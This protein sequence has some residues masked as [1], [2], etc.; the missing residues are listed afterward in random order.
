MRCHTVRLKCPPQWGMTA[1]PGRHKMEI[2]AASLR[3]VAGR[4]ARSWTAPEVRGCPKHLYQALALKADPR[5]HDY[6]LV[7]AKARGLVKAELMLKQLAAETVARAHLLHHLE[8]HCAVHSCDHSMLLQLLAPA[9]AH[10]CWGCTCHCA[11]PAAVN[12]SPQQD[13]H[14]EEESLM[15]V[16]GVSVLH[17]IPLTNSLGHPPL[18]SA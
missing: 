15:M 16:R 5:F 3:R 13:E 12:L 7:A 11:R 10:G 17:R 8:V 9:K 6:C 18:H 2:A 1:A 14:T 4:P